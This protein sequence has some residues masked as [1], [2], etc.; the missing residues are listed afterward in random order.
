MNILLILLGSHISHILNDRII[1]TVQFVKKMENANIHW[2][3][4]GGIK[5]PH[6]NA[7]SEAE[8]M[9]QIITTFKEESE[10]HWSYIYDTIATNTAEN[11]VLAKRFIHQSNITYDQIY[12]STSHF[13]AKRA[14]KFAENILDDINYQWILGS[15]KCEDSDYWE[16]IHI[17]NVET[18]IK[19]AFNKFL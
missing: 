7:I 10:N 5:Y 18:D 12:I 6:E 2:F 1:T 15:A 14:N 16:K 4:S 8:K 13:H 17:R 3:L 11:L 19:K 9:A